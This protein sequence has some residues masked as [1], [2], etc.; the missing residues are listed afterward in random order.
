MEF[1][2]YF[3]SIVAQPLPKCNGFPAAGERILPRAGKKATKLTSVL[4]QNR[5]A[6]IAMAV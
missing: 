3:R 2:L 1:S 5:Q 4:V 6:E